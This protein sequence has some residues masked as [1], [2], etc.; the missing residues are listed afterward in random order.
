M[1]TLGFEIQKSETKKRFKKMFF[2]NKMLFIVDICNFYYSIVSKAMQNC[3]SIDEIEQQIKSETM[4]FRNLLHQHTN[5]LIFIRDVSHPDITQFLKYLKKKLKMVT[6]INK[7]IFP[8]KAT[9][10]IIDTLK[11]NHVVLSNTHTVETD[12][13]IAGIAKSLARFN[14]SV[15][16]ISSD[17]DFQM[18]AELKKNPQVLIKQFTKYGKLVD[19]QKSRKTK[20]DRTL[21]YI[22]VYQDFKIEGVKYNNTQ[23]Q[24]YE[25]KNFGIATN[26]VST[27]NN[28]HFTF[29]HLRWYLY[30]IK[31][32]EKTIIERMVV[33]KKNHVNKKII[34]S[35][36]VFYVDS[37]KM[38]KCD[39]LAK[40]FKSQNTLFEYMIKLDNKQKNFL[41]SNDDDDGLHFYTIKKISHEYFGRYDSSFNH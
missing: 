7:T 6:N 29:R 8:I 5:K 40:H 26:L 12:D 31:S 18:Y 38:R 15:F 41:D 2:D 20:M 27:R 24:L 21:P 14:T 22:D 25:I 33:A 1:L 37:Q 35:W 32:C 34:F 36:K 13:L 9:Q 16:I 28:L 39:W 30:F 17:K 3:N 4:I 19:Q 11:K 23:K 10:L